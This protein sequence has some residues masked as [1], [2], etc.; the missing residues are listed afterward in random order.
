MKTLFVFVT[1]VAISTNAAE[2]DEDSGAID[3]GSRRELFVDSQLIEKRDGASLEMHRPQPR[4]VVMRFDKPWES[5]SPGYTTIIQE[6]G[7]AT[8][9]CTHSGLQANDLAPVAT[10]SYK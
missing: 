5:Y 1:L 4:E 6:S 7:S 8:P 10:E 2:A 3:I 9:I